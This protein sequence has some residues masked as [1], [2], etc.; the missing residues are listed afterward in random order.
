M[1]TLIETSLFN[2]ID[3]PEQLVVKGIPGYYD[4]SGNEILF[5]EGKF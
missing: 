2:Q 4:I 5:K 3:T 1:K